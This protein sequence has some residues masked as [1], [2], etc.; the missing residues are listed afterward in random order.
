MTAAG[1][2]D[3]VRQG[4]FQ[5][6]D[7]LIIE[8]PRATAALSMF[9]GQL[10]S[11]IPAGSAHDVL[12]VS[13]AA[14]PP[15]TPIRGGVPLC[16]PYFAR[17]GQPAGV[18]SHG[19][20]RTARWRLVAGRSTES[21]DTELELAPEGLEHLPLTAGM[22][23][24][25]GNTLELGLRTHNPGGATVTMTEAFHNYFRVADVGAV[26]VEGLGGLSYLDK[27][28][29][30]RSHEQQGD[31]TL[32]KDTAR[33]DRVYPGAGGRY[34]LVDPGLRR[35]IEVSVR[36]GHSAVV[37]NPGADVA[38]GMPDIGAHWREFLCVEAANAGPDIV[39]IPAGAD[40]TLWQTIS[41]STLA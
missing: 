3:G 37:W 11:F 31:W 34:R 21:G 14:A 4:S 19:Y 16:W 32:P 15:P 7:A 10:L 35:T 36:G 41:V 39:E 1:D 5:G 29:D 38:S 13:P 28:D 2:F 18:P 27:F 6:L 22:T 26:R 25:V 23:V 17:E 12:W 9:G 30:L 24:R 33:S 40:H 8:T 20:A